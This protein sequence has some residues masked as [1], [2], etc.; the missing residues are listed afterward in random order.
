MTGRAVAAAAATAGGTEPGPQA[1][2]SPQV[3]VGPLWRQV[4][5]RHFAAWPTWFGW[6]EELALDIFGRIY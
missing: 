5:L 1:P 2:G 3:W 4:F 6:G